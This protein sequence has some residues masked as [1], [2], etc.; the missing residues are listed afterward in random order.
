MKAKTIILC[1]LFSAQSL[2]AQDKPM[3]LQYGM[4]GVNNNLTVDQT[5]TNVAEWLGYIVSVCDSNLFRSFHAFR[6]ISDED[7]AILLAFDYPDSLLPQKQILENL[8]W[9]D[10][11][12]KDNGFR[13]IHTAC[14]NYP[15]FLPVNL[16]YFQNK[17]LKKRLD[18]LLSLPVT[19]ITYHQALGYCKWRTITDSLYFRQVDGPYIFRLPTIEEYKLMNENMDSIP[20]KSKRKDFY[21]FNYRDLKF[22]PSDSVTNASIGH[23]LVPIWEFY[24]TKLGLYAIQGNAA[25]MTSKEGTAYGGS[26]FQYAIE[27]YDGKTQSYNTAQPWLGMRCVAVRSLGAPH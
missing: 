8:E 10:L 18:Y 25:E 16:N 17:K 12:K 3:T 6:N 26:Y 27:S 19:G 15:Q 22:S 9:H 5:E 2:L 14:S 11:V 20:V 24:P 23:G 7:K 13:L 21:G 4:M 1:C